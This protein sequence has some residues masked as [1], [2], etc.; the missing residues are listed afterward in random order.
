MN[1]A[2]IKRHTVTDTAEIH[3]HAYNAAFYELG[4]RWCWDVDTYQYPLPDPDE[5]A[6]IRVYLET[7][8]RHLLTAYDADFLIDAIQATKTRCYENMK[9]CGV[10]AAPRVNWAEIQQ[11]QVGV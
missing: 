1:N 8:Q 6:R 9:A 4:L 10:T 11:E 3:R 7:H 5:K 2:T